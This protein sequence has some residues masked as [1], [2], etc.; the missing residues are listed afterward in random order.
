MKQNS[1]L[2]S[3][4]QEVNETPQDELENKASDDIVSEE[5]EEPKSDKVSLIPDLLHFLRIKCT[6]KF[7]SSKTTLMLLCSGVDGV[8]KEFFF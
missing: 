8:E 5:V 4:D 2:L 6:V 7:S 3:I 1:F